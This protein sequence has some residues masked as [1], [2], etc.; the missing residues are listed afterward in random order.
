[1]KKL[2]II[3]T[4]FLLFYTNLLLKIPSMTGGGGGGNHKTPFL[5]NHPFTGGGQ[6]VG[7]G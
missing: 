2:L 6:P 4:C 5:E 3:Q 1:M 7:G